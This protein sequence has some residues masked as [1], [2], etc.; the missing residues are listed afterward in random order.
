MYPRRVPSRPSNPHVPKRP[1][2]V[3]QLLHFNNLRI[4]VRYAAYKGVFDGFVE[5]FGQLDVFRVGQRLVP[6]KED[7]VVQPCLPEFAFD[8]F[9]GGRGVCEKAAEVDGFDE[10]ADVTGELSHFDVAVGP[11]C[12]WRGD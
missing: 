7:A 4:L 12:Q 8:F 3:R 10:A 6:E 5:H 11:G 9:G 2:L 1:R